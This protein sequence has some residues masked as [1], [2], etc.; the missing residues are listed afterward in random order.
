MIIEFK[1][2]G[3]S[4]VPLPPSAGVRSVTVDGAPR[5][6]V[7]LPGAGL[8]L[9]GGAPAGS[10]IRIDM[11]TLA[12]VWG[13][14][15]VQNLASLSLPE[16]A[17]YPRPSN[18]QSLAELAK[19]AASRAGGTLLFVEDNFLTLGPERIS[20]GSFVSGDGWSLNAS[21]VISSGAL[22]GS[23]SVAD[24]VKPTDNPFEAGKTY[25]VSWD[26]TSYSS[27][28][29]RFYAGSTSSTAPQSGVGRKVAVLTAT[30]APAYFGIQS[31]S[32][33]FS[34]S[35]DNVSV[36]EVLAASVWQEYT[37]ATPTYDGGPVGYLTDRA[38]P[39]NAS[40]TLGS[41]RPTT[42]KIGEAYMQQ[43]DGAND[44]LTLTTNPIGSAPASP[45]TIIVGLQVG[46]IG[47]NRRCCGD[48][49]RSLGVTSTNGLALINHGAGGVYGPLPSGAVT[50]GE[51]MVVEAVFDGSSGTLWKNG[52]LHA[53]G[54]LAPPS[55]TV[56]PFSIG[57]RGNQSEYWSGG[58]DVVF[59]AGSVLPEADRKA[60][61]RFA[62]KRIGVTYNG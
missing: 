59:V 55:N 34:G 46:G 29:V 5:A 24:L 35:I 50:V 1:H 10:A 2:N 61:A 58:S 3:G 56:N 8:E 20:N 41:A 25:L 22:N 45:Y 42:Q 47:A 7:E 16:K 60:I 6:F 54:P 21:W 31:G 38:G 43:Y 36:R 53:T 17:N 9:V 11:D 49:A 40:Q 52:T 57:Q 37:A 4:Y 26:I 32:S 14:W 44:S 39:N 15:D 13:V 62:A 51:C 28:D 18:P 33:G 23:P 30:A 48:S 12:E 27:G 19:A